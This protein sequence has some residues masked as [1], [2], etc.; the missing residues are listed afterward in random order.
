LV[1]HSDCSTGDGDCSR[2]P[3]VP[4]HGLILEAK[5]PQGVVLGENAALAGFFSR[6]MLRQET[7]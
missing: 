4:N 2:R 6:D 5:A 7:N 1:V 3:L